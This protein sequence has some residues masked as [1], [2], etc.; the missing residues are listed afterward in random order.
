MTNCKI[1]NVENTIQMIRTYKNEIDFDDNYYC[2]EH[3]IEIKS[4]IEEN[5]E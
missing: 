3:K 2:K 5:E 4:E 1:C